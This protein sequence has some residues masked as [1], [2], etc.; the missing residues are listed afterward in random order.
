LYYLKGCT[1]SNI[2]ASRA[3]FNNNKL[4]LNLCFFIYIR[5]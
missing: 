2:N 3:V 4:L 1:I 5:T